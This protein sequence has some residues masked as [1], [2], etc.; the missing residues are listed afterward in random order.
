M[1]P[2]LRPRAT[3]LLDRHYNS[4]K[5]YRKGAANIYAV[6]YGKTCVLSSVETVDGRMLLRPDD[7][8]FPIAVLSPEDGTQCPD[9]ILGRICYLQAEC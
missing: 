7:R 4:L 1:Y 5:Q 6:H 9:Y 2:R 3:V 8:T